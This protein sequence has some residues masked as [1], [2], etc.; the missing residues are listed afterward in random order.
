[1]GLSFKG[2]EDFFAS[3]FGMLSFFPGMPR[4]LLAQASPV[5]GR[6]GVV[7]FFDPVAGTAL[8]MGMPEDSPEG[9]KIFDF[10]ER[11]APFFFIKRHLEGY[12]RQQSVHPQA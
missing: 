1:M 5:E 7:L 9:G 4:E 10:P 3:F 2:G 12:F 11:C 6:T 8:H